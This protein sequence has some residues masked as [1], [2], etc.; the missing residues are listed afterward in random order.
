MLLYYFA[1]A[2]T[3]KILLYLF[4]KSLFSSYISSDKRFLRELFGC[5]LCLGVWVYA[6]LAVVF[7]IRVNL[8]SFLIVHDDMIINIIL[9][10]ITQFLTGAVTSFIVHL[11]SVGVDTEFR[12]LE[13]K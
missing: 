9:I 11:I 12:V 2:I 5:D 1:Y 8:F 3:G 13:I 4:Q 7:G 6:I 10:I